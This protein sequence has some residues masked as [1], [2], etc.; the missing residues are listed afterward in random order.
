MTQITEETCWCDLGS[1]PRSAITYK[2]YVQPVLDYGGELLSTA[3]DNVCKDHDKVQNR[4]L[5]L[6]TGA[7]KSTP[8]A[9]VEIQTEIELLN[10]R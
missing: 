4:A 2:T 3:P 8:V 6:I 10:I 7:A 9:S 1:Y 5:R